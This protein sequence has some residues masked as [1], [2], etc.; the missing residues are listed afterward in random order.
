MVKE[1]IDFI[2]R[3]LKTAAGS[4]RDTIIEVGPAYG[5]F[6]LLMPEYMNKIGIEPSEYYCTAVKQQEPSLKYFRS[7]LENVLLNYPALKESGDLVV[8]SHVLE[9]AH[10]PRSFIQCMKALVKKGGTLYIEVPSIEAL[11]DCELPLYQTL[12]FGHIS[13]F[14]FAVINQLCE[15]ESMECLAKEISAKLQY[16]VLRALYKIPNRIQETELMFSIHSTSVDAQTQKALKIL[17]QYINQASQALLLWGFGSDLF[18]VLNLLTDKE[19]KEF[20]KIAVLADINPDKQNR[21]FKGMPIK[22][23]QSFSGRKIDKIII[24]SR[25]Q[26]LK[27]DIIQSAKSLFPQADYIVLYD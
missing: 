16:P 24:S 15:S 18:E 8:A 9:H 13:Q 3:G 21:L 14:T 20:E 26:L 25:S 1:R 2:L 4:A 11:K 23:P 12:H 7:T 6:L 5:D 27:N 10:N 17:R 22:A 19:W